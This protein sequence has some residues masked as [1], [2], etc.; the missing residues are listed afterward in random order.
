MFPIE[1]P[2]KKS[3]AVE[4]QKQHKAR[5]YLNG[6]E[7][8]QIFGEKLFMGSDTGFQLKSIAQN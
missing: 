3:I 4:C 6:H 7:M 5:V 2:A 8:G 1:I